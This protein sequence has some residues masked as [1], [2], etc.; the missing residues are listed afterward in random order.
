LPR[1]LDRRTGN[2]GAWSRRSCLGSDCACC[3]CTVCCHFSWL[4]PV[5]YYRLVCSD[6]AHYLLRTTNTLFK[7]AHTHLAAARA[8]VVQI[9]DKLR[10]TRES[11]QAIFGVL[12]TL[13]ANLCEYS[14]IR[15]Q[16][17]NFLFI[18]HKRRKEKT[19][20][21]A[22]HTNACNTALKCIENAVQNRSQ[23]LHTPC[24]W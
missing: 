8:F 19:S 15:Y 16:R 2:G 13:G 1:V 10:W 3:R 23:L 18:S 24:G 5:P 21:V 6:T 20:C 14:K 4:V 12:K 22:S 9:L 17:R 7:R 11:F